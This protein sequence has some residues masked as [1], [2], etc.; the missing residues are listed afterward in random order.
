MIRVP[1]DSEEEESSLNASKLSGSEESM[2]TCNERESVV[3]VEEFECW[4][5]SD[6]GSV[7]E[8]ID[9]KVSM[10]L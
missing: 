2:F 9:K 5:E 8:D 6:C 3:M 4:E 1:S 7:D 10:R